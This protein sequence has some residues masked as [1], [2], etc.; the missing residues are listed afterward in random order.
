M[1]TNR[2]M[3][4]RS[5]RRGRMRS[6]PLGPSVGPHHGA[7]NRVRVCRS[8]RPGGGHA[9]TATWALG[10]APC[11]ATKRVIGLPERGGDACGH[12]HSGDRWMSRWGHEAREGCAAAGSGGA[13]MHRHSG[14]R[15]NSPWGYEPCDGVR[16]TEL[17]GR[18][19][20]PPQKPSVEPPIWGYEP[21]EDVPK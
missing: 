20:A 5:E 1:A 15:W 13:C 4:C 18:M 7:T 10:E 6:P 19:R 11:G 3:V 2:V 16:R 8:D 9:A 12:R 14:P 17:R 21:C